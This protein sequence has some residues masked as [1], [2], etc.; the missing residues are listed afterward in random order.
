MTAG[1]RRLG[2]R[3]DGTRGTHAGRTS[4]PRC[5][6]RWGQGDRNAPL[7]RSL[8]QKWGAVIVV[9]EP[10]AC[11]HVEQKI[12]GEPIYSWCT[13]VRHRCRRQVILPLLRLSVSEFT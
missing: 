2:L 12:W 13:P 10:P 9:L 8:C 11:D 6:G 4:R 7:H 3:R 5:L 1:C